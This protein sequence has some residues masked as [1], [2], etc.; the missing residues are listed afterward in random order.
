[1]IFIIL[2]PRGFDGT[3]EGA[4]DFSDPGSHADH[5]RAIYWVMAWPLLILSGATILLGFLQVPLERFLATEFTAI[6]IPERLHC[7]WLPYVALGLSFGG[8]GLAWFEFGRKG[9]RQV[10]FVECIPVLHK[11]FAER[12]YIDDFYRLFVDRV[13]DRGIAY[14][15]YENDNK[16]IDGGIDG[17][18]KGAVEGGRVMDLLHSTMIQY[19]LMMAFA[20]VVL[21]SL[22]FFF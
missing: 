18:C 8:V 3:G 4:K 9:A 10:G 22:Y 12:W 1:M 17:M 5:H 20:V 7:P 21:L 6:P 14:L 11:L 19:R 13:I 2:F 15:F 16:V